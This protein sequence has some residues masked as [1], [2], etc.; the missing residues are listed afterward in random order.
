MEKIKDE[1]GNTI[2]IN[3][4]WGIDDVLQVAKDNNIKLTRKQASDVLDET[5]RRHDATLGVSWETIE[6]HIDSILNKGKSGHY[7]SI[8]DNK[9]IP[10]KG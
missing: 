2:A 6:Y 7:F 4:T 3:L 8:K 1:K 5:L 10:N 9:L